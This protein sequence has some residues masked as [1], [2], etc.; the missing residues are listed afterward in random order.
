MSFKVVSGWTYPAEEMVAYRS[1]KPFFP[2][3]QPL[4]ADILPILITWP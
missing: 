2:L 3:L 4:Q 1:F